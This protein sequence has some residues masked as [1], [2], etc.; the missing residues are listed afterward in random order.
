M[1]PRFALA[2][3]S[4]LHIIADPK[5]GACDTAASLRAALTALAPFRPDAILATGDL[6]NDARPE[7]YAVLARILAEAPAPVFLLPGNHD[8]RDELRVHFPRHDYLPP[9]GSLSFVLDQ[10][11]VRLIGLDVTVPGKVHGLFAPAL[12]AWLDETLAAAPDRPTIVA[13]H[14]PPFV[15]GDRLFDTI[16]LERRQAF[17]AVIAGHAQV[18]LILAGH[19]HRGLVGRIA[20]APA[21]VAP[22]TAWTFGAALRNDQP[23]A[24][25]T[26]EPPGFALHLWQDEPGPTTLFFGVP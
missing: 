10:L 23:I 22:S 19:Q 14:H 8:S 9:E 25:R 24:P 13:L 15:I 3:I 12:E 26:Q 6:A 11:P 1:S 21:V 4:D 5:P 18:E 16:A 2:Q 20:H 7:E 17:A